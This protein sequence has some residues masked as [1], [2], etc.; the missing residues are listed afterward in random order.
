MVLLDYAVRGTVLNVL[1]FA[2][3]SP[4][5]YNFVAFVGMF[6][7]Y[8]PEKYVNQ[9]KRSKLDTLKSIDWPGALMSVSGIT[10]L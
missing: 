3:L 7:T 6:F 2:K 5:I 10:L 4:R 1:K 9:D 8:F